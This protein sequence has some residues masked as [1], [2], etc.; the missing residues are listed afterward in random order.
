MIIRKITRIVTLPINDCMSC[1]YLKTMMNYGTHHYRC[2]KIGCETS[3][4]D[5]SRED[6]NETKKERQYWFNNLCTLEEL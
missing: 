3:E 2:D 6:E 4:T 1:P 5:G